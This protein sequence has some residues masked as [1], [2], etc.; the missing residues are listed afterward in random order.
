MPPLV[1]LEF[2]GRYAAML[3]HEPKNYA[4]LR[5]DGTLLLRGVAFR[6]SRVEPFG[7]EFLQRAIY[8]LLVRDTPGVRAAFAETVLAL[9]SRSMPTAR[10][11][12]QLRLTKSPQQYLA[13]RASRREAAYEALLLS[14]REHWK[15]GERV[16]VY[17]AAG[18]R[19]ALLEETSP[20]PN[21][22]EGENEGPRD[23]DVAYYVRLLRETFA[24]RLARA[25]SAEDFAALFADPEQPSLFDPPVASIQA[26][27]EPP[28]GPP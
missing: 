23:Y 13:T 15:V 12:A 4:L 27:S 6:S 24:A 26:R 17:R 20:L 8:C 21:A 11:A 25:F 7:E 16:R 14:G 28:H 2:E 10:L 9:R 22:G 19:A 1:R 5:Y 3:S 18:R